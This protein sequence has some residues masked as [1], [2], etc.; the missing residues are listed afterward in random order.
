[1]GD[2]VGVAVGVAFEGVGDGEAVGV[3]VGLAVGVGVGFA[4]TGVGVA[5]RLQAQV[6]LVGAVIVKVTTDVPPDAGTLP[7]PDQPV[8][9]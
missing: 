7:V 5:G 6:R 4:G 9:V 2:A 8:Q 3:V 1:M